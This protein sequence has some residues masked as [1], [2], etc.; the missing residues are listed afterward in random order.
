MKMAGRRKGALYSFPVCTVSVFTTSP[1]LT[2]F[3]AGF[4]LLVFVVGLGT[5]AVSVP[6]ESMVV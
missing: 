1:G 4:S 6:F 3:L 5:T 2:C